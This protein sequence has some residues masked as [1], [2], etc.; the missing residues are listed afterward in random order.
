M[1]NPTP[2]QI[3]EALRC[4]GTTGCNCKE[5]LFRGHG[6]DCS[7]LAMQAAADMI[8]AQEKRIKELETVVEKGREA[9]R[10]IFGGILPGV[11]PL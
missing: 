8:E 7:V 10:F 6:E 9:F 5:C 3:V 11:E 1:S 4:T 2:E